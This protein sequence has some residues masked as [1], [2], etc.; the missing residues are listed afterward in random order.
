MMGNQLESNMAHELEARY[1]AHE[2]EAEVQ[3]TTWGLEEFTASQV[4]IV[5]RTGY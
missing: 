2:M 5:W 3:R 4:T 1:M